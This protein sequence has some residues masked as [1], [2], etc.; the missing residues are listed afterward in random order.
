MCSDPDQQIC[1]V[2]MYAHHTIDSSCI[3]IDL[4]TI[5]SSPN[6]DIIISLSTGMCNVQW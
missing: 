3:R 1:M 4:P 5:D 2:Y 6:D